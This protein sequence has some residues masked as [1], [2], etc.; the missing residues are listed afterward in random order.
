M[1]LFEHVLII[2]GNEEFPIMKQTVHTDA[3]KP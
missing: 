1:T 3:N 2:H